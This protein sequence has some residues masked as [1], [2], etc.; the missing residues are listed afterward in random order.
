M[1]L[2][3]GRLAGVPS[4][5]AGGDYSVQVWTNDTVRF[6]PDLAADTVPCAVGDYRLDAGRIRLKLHRHCPHARTSL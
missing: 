4:I 3:R 2:F 1:L 5:P 6:A